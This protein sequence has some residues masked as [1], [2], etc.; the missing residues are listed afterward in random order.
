[1]LNDGDS[2]HP[3]NYMGCSHAKEELQRRKNQRTTNEGSSGR[4][5]FT[6]Y[7]APDRSFASVPR[8]PAEKKQ[9]ESAGPQKQ[10]VTNKA[11]GQSMQANV[12]N[13]AMDDMYYTRPH[14]LTHTV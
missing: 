12:N 13:N 11:S 10:Q 1:M 6:K 4:T 9:K 8:C 3:A 7:T 5:F 2:P 14:S